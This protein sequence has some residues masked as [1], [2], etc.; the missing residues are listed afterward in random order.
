MT[1]VRIAK[2]G[3]AVV[4]T[5]ALLSACAAGVVEPDSTTAAVTQP[6]ATLSAGW[7]WE[8][9]LPLPAGYQWPELANWQ[10]YFQQAADERIQYS[11]LEVYTCSWMD[12]AIGA[13]QAND[14]ARYDAAIGQLDVADSLSPVLPEHVLRAHIIDPARGMQIDTLSDY[15]KTQCPVFFTPKFVK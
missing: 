1:S 8:W 14:R 6:G 12:E 3:T 7:P 11:A 5:V 4:A 13:R 2:A 9:E 15:V 10:S